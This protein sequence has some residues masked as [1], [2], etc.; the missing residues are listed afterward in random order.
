MSPL[1][2]APEMVARPV[3]TALVL[4]GTAPHI[5]LIQSLKTRGWRVV[6]V[7]YLDAPPAAPHADLHV[8][9]STLDPEAVEAVARAEGA[10]LVIATCVDQ[11]NVIAAQVSERLGLPAPYSFATAALI[12]NKGAMK[13]RLA[14]AG[15]P[16]ARHVSLT[17]ADLAGL[18]TKI[19]ALHFPLIVKPADSNGSNGVRRADD[20][21]AL[22]THLTTALEISRVGEAI[23]E[24]FLEG[25]E[26]SVDCFI[27]K[28]RAR[29]VLVRRK[30]P[31]IGVPEGKVIQSTGSIAPHDL[32]DQA[33][34][35]EET[36][37]KLARAFDL[38]NVPMLVQGFLSPRGFHLIEFSPR[39]S[40]GTGSAVTKQV[41]GFDAIEASLD[42]WL[43]NPVEVTLNPP[44][45]VL[46][47]NTLYAAP[48]TFDR[49]EGI[50]ALLEE[51]VIAR[52]M[53]YKTPGMEIGDDMSTR[54]RVGAFLVTAP[55]SATAFA[56]TRAA[57]A[58]I[59][60]YDTQG[61]A[62]LRRDVL[63]QLR[64]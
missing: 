36:L 50:E 12:G 58:R 45:I 4:G 60:A 27:E 55:D 17:K 23:V 32:G 64:D 15:L 5:A 2:G 56:R 19:A 57:I 16:T 37:S 34:E 9:E 28:G 24:E 40:G 38:D 41:S 63:S 3:P 46:M 10:S 29:I 33:A 48:G 52:W 39:L 1:W 61:H 30:F 13:D 31:M 11:A 49:I 25:D 35:V 62:L 26:L 51:G 54:S 53:P 47:T 14:E 43:G 44:G 6:L 22:R 42:S 20:L 8:Q 18:E 7:D 21:A 59:E